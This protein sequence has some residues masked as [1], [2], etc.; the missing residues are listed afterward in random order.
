MI[1][2]LDGGMPPAAFCQL[3]RV[4]AKA[5]SFCDP[6]VENVWLMARLRGICRLL[7]MRQLYSLGNEAH[8]IDKCVHHN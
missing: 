7:T 8:A 6:Q 3:G 4:Q 5:A 2:A 1:I